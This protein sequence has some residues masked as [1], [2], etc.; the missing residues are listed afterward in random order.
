MKTMLLITALA[1]CGFGADAT[2]TWTGTIQIPAS[3]NR[4]ARSV[5][6]HLVLKQEGATITGTAG[7]D[8]AQQFA[9]RNGTVDH[10]TLRFDAPAG[11][12]VMKFVL[13]Q[14]GDQIRGEVSREREGASPEK[15]T[16]SVKRAGVPLADE[17]ASLDAVLFGA[18]NECNLEKFASLVADDIEFYHD[19][20]GRTDGPKAMLDA[21]KNNIC[22]KVRRELV[23]DS[24]KVWPIPGYGAIQE[25]QHRFSNSGGP[26]G[27][28]AKFLHVW[29]NKAGQW[30]LSRV[31]SYDHH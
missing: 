4:E 10:A 27:Q 11:E 5:P 8:A 22:G 18:Y 30:K 7:P 19:K 31:V 3:N 25:G 17:I 21:L 12:A 29:Q 28:P 2:G 23:R 26:F 6:A 14:E 1:M 13:I 15:S 24:M 20:G 16:I 9:I